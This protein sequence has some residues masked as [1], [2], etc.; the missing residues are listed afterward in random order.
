M[1]YRGISSHERDGMIFLLI[2]DPE[3]G[4]LTFL[5][6]IEET[7]LPIKIEPASNYKSS[8]RI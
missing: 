5:K 3:S 1:R 4:Q 7:A 6:T 8:V 2:H